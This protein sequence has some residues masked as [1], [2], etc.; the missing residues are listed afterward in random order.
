MI[1]LVIQPNPHVLSGKVSMH[2]SYIDNKAA[3]GSFLD[4]RVRSSQ[5]ASIRISEILKDRLTTDTNIR[6]SFRYCPSHSGIEGN[7]HADRLTKHG[8]ALAPISPPRI[9]LSNFVNDYTIAS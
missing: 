2:V 9:L 4:T 5:M 1:G 6:F 7:D 3:L 8:A